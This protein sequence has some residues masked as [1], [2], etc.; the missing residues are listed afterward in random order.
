MITSTV[1]ALLSGLPC[2][3]K[4]MTPHHSRDR[5]TGPIPN[6]QCPGLH[7]N[8]T[9]T[10]IEL[11]HLL[12]QEPRHDE[13]IAVLTPLATVGSSQA[14]HELAKTLEAK[15]KLDEAIVWYQKSA[16][17]G[18]FGAAH[19]AVRLMLRAERASEAL[20]WL[21]SIS[22]PDASH[23]RVECAEWV[24][25]SM[26]RDEE[27]KRVRSY[28]WEPDGSISTPWSITPPSSKEG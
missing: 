26:G 8:S 11:A 3:T 25:A 28:G 5:R 22:D 7:E 13:A 4:D 9:R 27:A 12:Q 17:D 2:Y 10:S 19:G 20:A 1:P 14:Q 18:T 24:L 6:V 23:E 21:R 15:E 16:E